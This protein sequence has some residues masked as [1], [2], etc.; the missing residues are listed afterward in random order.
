MGDLDAALGRV[1]AQRHA[2]HVRDV[3]RVDRV[4]D[5][6][7]V[8]GLNGERRDHDAL[9]RITDGHVHVAE[10]AGPKPVLV[11]RVVDGAGHLHEARARIG[12]GRDQDDLRDVGPCAL[13][14]RDAGV[15]PRL[16]ARR[17]GLG[18]GKPQE[19]RIALEQRGEDGAWL[20]VLAP[21]DRAR[22]DDACE[23]RAHR[24]VAEVQLGDPHRLLCGVG[25]GLRARDARRVLIDL[26]AGHE[27]GVRGDR[28]LPSRE[29]GLGGLVRRDGLVESGLRLVDRDL[30]ALDL[31]DDQR[32]AFFHGL[33]LDEGDLV[34][35]A[36]DARGDLDLLERVD[37]AR[38]H[39]VVL[40]LAD[41]ERR[42]LHRVLELVD[43]L[44]LLE[45]VFGPL[46]AGERRGRRGASEDE[47]DR[48]SRLLHLSSVPSG[49]RPIAWRKFR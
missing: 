3:A 39:H 19:Q 1:H 48:S 23:G 41:L 25:V 14:Q 26:F 33:P 17:V 27:A 34:D 20:E 10:C 32:V 13:A 30:V 4:N 9:T 38:R 5:V 49:S 8:G 2:A 28:A 24:G 47:R 37:A 18:H 29:L 6:A 21:L 22:L 7:L 45:R 11:I 40:N 44:R 12:S 42:D 43:G 36:G 15:H 46:R 35:R 16:H 31:D